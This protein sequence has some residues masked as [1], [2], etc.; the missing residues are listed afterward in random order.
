MIRDVVL[1]VGGWIWV[2]SGGNGRNQGGFVA[3]ADVSNNLG[4]GR[5]IKKYALQSL[6]RITAQYRICGCGT[7]KFFPRPPSSAQ[8]TVVSCPPGKSPPQRAKKSPVH[9]S[10][11]STTHTETHHSQTDRRAEG[12][13]PA[14]LWL[15]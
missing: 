6:L 4:S 8:Y 1:A 5:R 14:C 3:V 10:K 7:G 11:G 13:V 2:F 9:Y 12:A 15:S